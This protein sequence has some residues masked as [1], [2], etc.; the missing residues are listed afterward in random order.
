M[1]VQSL[2]KSGI[3]RDKIKHVTGHKSTFSIELYD[4][5][6]SDDEQTKFSDIFTNTRCT[7][8]NEI[9]TAKDNK[10]FASGAL[11]ARLLR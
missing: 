6:L 10:S 2:R 4:D 7:T 11:Y 5:G 1:C 9:S 8:Q 3:A